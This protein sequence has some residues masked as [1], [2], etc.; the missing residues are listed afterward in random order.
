MSELL[1]AFSSSRPITEVEDLRHRL[2]GVR[3]RK[4]V[5]ECVHFFRILGGNVRQ[6]YFPIIRGVWIMLR[7]VLVRETQRALKTCVWLQRTDPPLRKMTH[8]WT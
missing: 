6:S 1:M 5:P 2:P 7:L 8:I 4:N 3:E